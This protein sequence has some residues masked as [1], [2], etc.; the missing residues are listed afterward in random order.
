MVKAL[1]IACLGVLGFAGAH[2]PRSDV[3]KAFDKFLKDFSKD[4]D[5]VEKQARF[6]AFADNFEYI[7]R[8]N[9]K[10]H[11][12]QLGLNEFSDLSLDEF[13]MNKLGLKLPESVWGEL[14][15]LGMHKAS[16][17]SLPSSVD[18]RSKAV[19]PVKNQQQCG[20][21]WAFS[22]TGALEGAWAIATSK[23]VSLS[24]QQLVDCSKKFGNE[25][26]SGGLMDN[27]FKYEE[28]APVC[29]ED[30][31]PYLAKNGICKA[32]GC[33]VGIPAH[34]VTGY[35]DVKADDEQSLM[36]AVSKQPVSVAIE[37]DQMAF[38]L[39]KGGVLS[40]TCGTKLDHGVL[41][42]GYGTEDGK[43]YWLV[44]NSWGST[45][46]ESGYVK[47]ERGKPG[48]GECG[49]KSQASYPV[50]HYEKPPCQKDE[51][52]AEVEGAGG[53]V[54]APKC[55][56][57][58]CPTDVPEGTTAKPMCILQ[59]ESSG[60][61]YCA[62]ACIVG[63]CPDGSKC[64]HLS[65]LLGVCIYPDS[66]SSM[67]LGVVPDSSEITAEAM[68]SVARRCPRFV[69]NAFNTK[70]APFSP[71]LQRTEQTTAPSD[72]LA[73]AF[74]LKAVVREDNLAKM[75]DLFHTRFPGLVC[76]VTAGG[77]VAERKTTATRISGTLRLF[78]MDQVGQL[79]KIS[80]VLHACGMT[81][82]NLHVTTGVCD[83]ETCEFVVREGGPLSENVITVAAMNK[84]TFEEETFRNEV[85]DASQEVGYAVTSIILEGEKHR[86]QQ[87][88]RYYLRRKSFMGEWAKGHTKPSCILA[89]S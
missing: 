68:L 4:Y 35:K 34:G 25:G 30:S 82:L 1:S 84:E 26:C 86:P 16:N 59:D 38:Q 13:K 71:S 76:T 21:C 63:G 62:L 46:G 7:T 83:V 88:A 89:A 51:T 19:T 64:V 74:L 66:S 28:Q 58:S 44:K 75:S 50:V 85:E 78:G 54:C 77:A 56:T 20:S 12:Y 5:D 3:E 24:E 41:V 67:K 49:I 37:A 40:K 22:T 11:S 23:L 60:D 47:L 17:S 42:V 61:K 14:P 39:Y 79:A 6:G 57:G 36:D 69:V 10:G 31:Y 9:A 27:G 53:S 8:E 45:W 52:Q 29:T 72:E 55:N 48:P 32:S 15:S 80:E 70:I 81:I 65:S 33:K 18:W 43:D 73:V 87:L 2:K